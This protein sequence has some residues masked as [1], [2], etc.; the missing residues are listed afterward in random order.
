MVTK[1]KLTPLTRYADWGISRVGNVVSFGCGDVKVLKTDLRIVAE[2]KQSSG[3][4]EFQLA[5]ARL[6]A[7]SRRNSYSHERSEGDILRIPSE[8]LL[9]IA[10]N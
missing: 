10:G 8:T 4:K 1:P 9:R 5:L 6:S 3:F 7:A 2:M